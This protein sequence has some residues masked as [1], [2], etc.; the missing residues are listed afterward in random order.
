[1]FAEFG[2]T[3]DKFRDKVWESRPRSP[4]P[5]CMATELDDQLATATLSEDTVRRLVALM[6]EAL[7]DDLRALWLYGSRARG[8]IPARR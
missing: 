6:N 7:G 8:E 2:G 3:G 5:Q 1:M 4:H